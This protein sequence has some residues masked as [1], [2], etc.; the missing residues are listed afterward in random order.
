MTEPKPT[1][2]D[3]WRN[4]LA[5]VKEDGLPSRYAMYRMTPE[6]EQA[7]YKRSAEVLSSYWGST[8]RVLDVGCGVGDLVELLP[9]GTAYLGIDLVPEFIQEAALTYT[10]KQ[11]VSFAVCDMTDLSQL[12]QLPGGFTLAVGRFV[13]TT[14]G[15]S[16]PDL[17]PSIVQVIL[18]KAPV[19]VLFSP[20]EE[21][22]EV[23][24]RSS[25]DGK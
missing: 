6:D 9:E 21:S 18:E 22:P 11:K 8:S 19:F 12:K 16:V 10:H 13:R 7:F 5:K 24:Y 17:W 1:S 15:N 23:I 2:I 3:F 4:R 25:G 14:I 20:G